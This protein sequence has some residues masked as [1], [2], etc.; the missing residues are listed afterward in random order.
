MTVFRATLRYLIGGLYG[1]NCKEE[2]WEEPNR[3][4]YLF[5]GKDK[6]TPEDRLFLA[7]RAW[8]YLGYTT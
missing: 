5:R 7:Y 4:K 1:D 2:D 8:K 6:W 3:L